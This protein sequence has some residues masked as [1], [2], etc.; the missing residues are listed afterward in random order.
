MIN[1]AV[2]ENML[3]MGPVSSLL[4]NFVF[5]ASFNQAASQTQTIDYEIGFSL[6]APAKTK[7]AP[8]DGQALF[9]VGNMFAGTSINVYKVEDFDEDSPAYLVN[10]IH[11]GEDYEVTVNIFELDPCS[12][13][14]IEI[15]ALLTHLREGGV[16]DEVARPVLIWDDDGSP[17]DGY[18][19]FEKANYVRLFKEC[20]GQNFGLRNPYVEHV[21]NLGKIVSA[22]N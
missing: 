15:T 7:A 13:S 16:I 18:R 11:N 8:D 1:L 2:A 4:A 10:G 17:L 12:A 3:G 21:M 20:Y 19:P 22:L 9:S 6:P 14:E 5:G